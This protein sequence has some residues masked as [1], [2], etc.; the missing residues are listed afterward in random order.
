MGSFFSHKDTE[1]PDLDYCSFSLKFQ[2]APLHGC[3]L[4]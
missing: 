2:R 3:G 4:V 1:N